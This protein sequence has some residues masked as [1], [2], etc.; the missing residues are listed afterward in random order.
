MLAPRWIVAMLV[1]VAVCAAGERA[2]A[3]EASLA[4]VATPGVSRQPF[5][6]MP[7][8]TV[9]DVFTLT[10]RN[11][12]EIKAIS[13]GAIITAIRVPD[14]AGAFADI[15][16]GYD[17]LDEYLKRHPYFGAIV[18][19]YGN[20]IGKAQFSLNGQTYKLAANDGPNHLHG[21]VNGFDRFVWHAEPLP[22]GS[23]VV[24]SRTSP[25]G[26]EG[27]P[28]TLKVRVTYTLTDANE[29][30]VDYE[31]TTDKATPVN[32][33]QHS[34]WNLSG[35]AAGDI[36]A[37]A[38]TLYADRYT[39]VDSTLIPTGELAPVEGTPF[40]FR[41]STAIGARIGQAHE[42]LKFGRGYDHNWVLTRKGGG[43]QPAARV[44]DPRS[45]R[46]LTVATTEPGV[47]FYTGNFLDGSGT[48]KGGVVYKHRTAFCLETQH[49]P[50]SPNKPNFPS[51]ILKP[52]QTYRSRTVFTF[53]VA[54]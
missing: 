31:A 54:K 32:L 43:L 8:G 24:F 30:A 39:P 41:K 29:L 35:H 26:E 20:R 28:G 5:G 27:Y 14:R 16:H 34:Y 38:L 46:T 52:G 9:V 1:G 22:E 50:D 7:D 25:D 40:D 48:G 49:F 4:P 33:T 17:T 21:G 19:R 42:Q 51:T 6:K 36:L 3:A 47:Q 23:G 18:G 45:G 11:G 53:G 37:H 44:V 2:R 13:Y 15:V 10:N 12:V